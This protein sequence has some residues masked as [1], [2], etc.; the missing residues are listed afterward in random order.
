MRRAGAA[1]GAGGMGRLTTADSVAVSR[2]AVPT[3]WPLCR[4]R[5]GREGL[6]RT[7]P[8][9]PR[10]GSRPVTARAFMNNVCRSLPAAQRAARASTS[11]AC[12]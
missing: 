4:R 6:S 12:R 9:N 5:A 8:P 3:P 1:T 11:R 2:G 10:R 7:H